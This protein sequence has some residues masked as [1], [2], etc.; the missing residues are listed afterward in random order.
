MKLQNFTLRIKEKL[1]QSILE[2][3]IE[4]GIFEIE[5]NGEILGHIEYESIIEG[6]R[7]LYQTG[8]D[9]PP[10]YS[11]AVVTFRNIVV[12]CFF[13][14]NDRELPNVISMLN[15]NLAA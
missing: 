14:T 13:S 7:F 9:S 11:N 12:A 10:E 4:G 3:G 8:Y 5:H 6:G 15:R 1:E 2:T